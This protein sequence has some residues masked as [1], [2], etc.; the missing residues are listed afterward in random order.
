MQLIEVNDRRTIRD[1]HRVPRRIYTG[2]PNWIPHLEKDVE[3][4]FD[5]SA[6]ARFANGEAIR[7]I[8]R[9]AHGN[10]LGRVAA[11]IDYS[12]SD[13]EKQPT[14]GMGF[15]EC[16]DDEKAAFLLFDTC[17][18]WLMQR[19]MEAMDGPINF[20][21]KERF[22]GLLVDGHRWRPPYLMNY[23]P[24][25]YRQLFESYGFRNYFEQYVYHIPTDTELPAIL[26]K[27]FQRLTDTQGYHFEHMKIKHI[28]KYAEDFMMIYNKAWG[29]AHKNFIPMTKIQALQIFQSMKSVIDEELVVFGYHEDKPVAF[30]VS[31]PELN[32]LFRYVNGKL[33]FLGKLKFLY[34][35]WRGKCRTIYGLV[36]GIVPEY[37]HRGLESA[38]I[39]SLKQ[40]V[41]RR[42]FYSGMYITWLGDF[43]PKMIRIVEHVQAKKRFTL[44]TYRHLF[45]RQAN[46]ERHPVLK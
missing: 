15:F 4:V 12:R 45:D 41:S 3:A 7:W 2:Y 16:I 29:K 19:G 24:P 44:I 11:F 46:F 26:K 37:Q 18:D 22:W 35:R 1:F 36:F 21:E 34:Y 10:L 8:L 43:N 14:G 39:M 5:P 31:I 6:N 33:N 42:N 17:K 13:K 9:D 38:L 27:K 23:Q 20:G 28:D 40:I 25:Y 32:E 30:I